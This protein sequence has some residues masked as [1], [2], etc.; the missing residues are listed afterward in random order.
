MTLTAQHMVAAPQGTFT[1]AYDQG[2][3]VISRIDG[4]TSSVL[5]RQPV[6]D[7]YQ[8]LESGAPLGGSNVWTMTCPT[9]TGGEPLRIIFGSMFPADNGEYVGPP[10]AGT[11]A[12]DGL[13]LYVLAPG[14]IDPGA[15]IQVE[16]SGGGIGVDA[17]TFDL[18][19]NSGAS[20][21]SG[22]RVA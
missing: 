6:P 12:S 3:V 10:A 21:A 20:Q 19:L 22:C 2:A 7:V 13:Y 4:T 9:A 17:S 16:T 18:T 8:P 14:H 5:G 15:L 11:F 1:I